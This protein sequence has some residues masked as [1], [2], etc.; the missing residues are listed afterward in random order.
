MGKRI[1]ERLHDLARVVDAERGLRDCRDTI[2]ILDCDSARLRDAA[3]QHHFA[4]RD[5]EGALH[6]LVAGMANQDN[7]AALVVVLFDFE[8]DLG[9]ERA[10]GV[11]NPQFAIL[12]AVPF[13]GRDAM[14]AENDAL[15]GG[16]LVEALDKNRALAFQRLEHEA[17]VHD[18]MAHVERASVGAQRAA[19][20][21]DGT[22]D[23]G[24][25]SAR[26]SQDNFFDRSNAQRHATICNW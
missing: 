23:A 11:D 20:G 13:A 25:K 10:G 18:L 7:G 3:D 9:D 12:G 4:G 16:H 17:V 1:L 2:A 5:A 22:I 19:D 14:S 15:A 8:M 6:F 26:L 21:L 24:A